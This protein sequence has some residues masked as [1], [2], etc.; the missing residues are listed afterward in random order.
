MPQRHRFPA[1]ACRISSVDGVGFAATSA[2]ADT[3]WPGVQKPHCT[4]SVRTNACTSGWSRSP[5]IVVTSCPSRV[6]TSVM[7]ESVGTPSIITVH[8]PQ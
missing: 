7:H 8:A 1:M 2:A 3:I 6:W 4:A 5:S